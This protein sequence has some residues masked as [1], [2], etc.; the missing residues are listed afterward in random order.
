MRAAAFWAQ[1]LGQWP[2]CLRVAARRTERFPAAVSCRAAD[3]KPPGVPRLVCA[4]GG[5]R[6]PAELAEAGLVDETKQI[7]TDPGKAYGPPRN[8][9]QLR[10]QGQQVNRKLV[11]QLMG[12]VL[13]GE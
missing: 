2:C 12:N 7:H 11:E 13:A 4:P 8:A 5:G 9:A 10:P 3:S 6:W 1:G